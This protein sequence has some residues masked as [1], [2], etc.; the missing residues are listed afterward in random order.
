M[1]EKQEKHNM[2]KVMRQNKYKKCKVQKILNISNIFNKL[3]FFFYQVHKKV[4]L[5][6]RYHIHLNFRILKGYHT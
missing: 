6:L 5:L 1:Y 4:F 3:A 2:Q